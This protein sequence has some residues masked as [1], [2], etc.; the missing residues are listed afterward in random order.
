[1]REFDELNHDLRNPNF[2]VDQ[3]DLFWRLSDR[4][5]VLHWL[6]GHA[7]RRRDHLP[8]CAAGP[9]ALHIWY[10]CRH[11]Q[12]IRNVFGG[13]GGRAIGEE[14]GLSA[15]DVCPTDFDENPKG[16]QQT[17]DCE[18]AQ[19]SVPLIISIVVL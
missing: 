15:G 4:V 6:D 16:A 8:C 5:V 2:E 18:N 9:S 7:G 3:L 12:G 11:R 13:Q 1:M 10:R 14:E 19:D 17:R